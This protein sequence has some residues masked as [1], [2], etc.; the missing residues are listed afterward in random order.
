MLSISM[1][2][3]HPYLL[4]LLI[5][6]LVL[7]V[8]PYFRLSKKYR[9]TRN[10]ITSMVLHGVLSTLAVLLLAGT[11]FVRSK[12]NPNNELI[13]LVD[14]SDTENQ[15]KEA[16]DRFVNDL[17]NQCSYDGVK[18]GIVTFG[19]DQEYVAEL[20]NEY[21]DLY[22]K[23]KDAE[24]PDVSA[25]NIASAI[26]YAKTLFTNYE[27]GKMVIVTDGKETDENAKTVIKGVVA[28]GLKVDTVYVPSLYDGDEVELTH[29]EFPEYHIN[30]G[31]EFNMTLNIKS[32]YE[33]DVTIQLFDNGVTSAVNEESVTLVEG[34]QKVTFKHIFANDGLHEL[35]FKIS[36]LE[37]LVQENNEYRSYMYVES[38]N[39]ILILEQ[40]LGESNLLRTVLT[41]NNDFQVETLNVK[42]DTLP[43]TALELCAYD[44]IILNNIA[45]SDMEPGFVEIL[46]EYV[47][48]YGGGLFTTGGNESGDGLTSHSYN[49]TDMIG[50][51]YQ[52]MLPVQ[53]VDYTPPVG[54]IFIIDRSGSMSET[55]EDGSTLL[56]WAKAGAYSAAINSLKTGDYVGIM[57][58][59]TD[60]NI[61]LELTPR[62]QE[63][64]IRSAINSID[65]A[66]GSTTFSG[67]IE[68]AGQILRAAKN[69]DK[70][71]IVIIS[72]GYVTETE[73]D[74]YEGYAKSYYETDGITISVVGVSM[75]TPL[76][77]MTYINETNI[78]NI[79]SVGAYYMMLRLTKLGHG[80][81]HAIPTSESA[82]IV[83]EMREDLKAPD[84]KEVSD[85][86]FYPIIVNNTAS[87]FNGVERLNDE[88]HGNTMTM[89]VEGFYGTKIKDGATLLLTG[90][91]NVPLYAQWKYGNGMVG[92]FMSDV[93]GLYTSD[94]MSDVNGTTFLKNA[95]K[96][97]TPLKNIR[98]NDIKLTL[99]EDN[100]SNQ[101]S[102]L[103]GFNEGEYLE[104]TI[105]YLDSELGTVE[106]PMNT[107]VEEATKETIRNSSVFVLTPMTE[108]N[109]Y[110][111]CKF[112]IR[113]PGTYTIE[114]NKFN[115]AGE[116][117]GSNTL[118]KTLA[119]SKEY[120]AFEDEDYNPKEL[121][122]ALSQNGN[123]IIVD[124]LTD[125]HSIIESFETTIFK[126]FDPRYLFSIIIIV[127]FLLDVAVRKFKFKWP[128]EI[129][130]KIRENKM[131]G[132]KE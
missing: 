37:D 108:A 68:R 77:A 74:T 83:P 12:T 51:L 29:V 48:N 26:N 2:F 42:T 27:S 65:T 22:D 98:D 106:I 100:Y 21:D 35:S 114:I 66:D 82:R 95:I 105:K 131:A 47:Y 5:P 30:K 24:L 118:H 58:L 16:R 61:I 87:V 55:A 70:K 69:V 15:V 72:D 63:A 129:I 44:E 7:T 122:T 52:Q 91:Y 73:H 78:D 20:T 40:N 34:E 57:S 107:I 53:V 76:D 36:G 88:D 38:F 84:I 110:S 31:E 13:I 45:N 11:I 50:S 28:S 4:L 121:L 93:Y 1:R 71:H 6:F 92:S 96:S 111:R 99:Y 128:H 113:K 49:R 125:S 46:N 67:A 120:E 109:N 32:N 17:I 33:Q 23:Y 104:G 89:Q 101:L 97:L 79:P 112:I 116:L 86:P 41:E 75:S 115:E 80:R 64:K 102:I 130:Q 54:V 25:T 103:T 124:D 59:E 81:L 126:E 60:Y 119:Y 123:G 62:T 94:F 117:V 56:E 127:L 90:E 14:V 8:L 9:K 132:D 3:E 39:K 85:E 19:Y 10:R 18:V 43:T